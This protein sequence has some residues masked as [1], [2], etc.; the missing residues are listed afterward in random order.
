MPQ[1]HLH[2]HGM[3]DQ[4][5]LLS[6]PGIGNADQVGRAGRVHRSRDA[7]VRRQRIAHDY[8]IIG[9]GHLDQFT[10]CCGNT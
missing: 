8:H 7:D 9:T 2:D 5:Q 6:I 4:R 3:I 10:R 1:L